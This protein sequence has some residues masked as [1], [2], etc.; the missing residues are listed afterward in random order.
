MK[1]LTGKQMKELLTRFDSLEVRLD[2]LEAKF[3]NL[4]KKVDNLDKKVDDLDKKAD[5]LDKKVDNLDKKVDDYHTE[6]QIELIKIKALAEGADFKFN[7]M[8]FVVSS[9]LTIIILG[10]GT[11]LVNQKDSTDEIMNEFR[12]ELKEQRT[13]IK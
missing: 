9:L 1:I 8:T 10:G 6:T 11:Y 3:D 12:Q 4:D 7:V 5:N 2:R 13:L